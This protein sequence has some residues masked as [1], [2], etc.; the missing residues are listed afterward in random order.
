[1]NLLYSFWSKS[2]P[3]KITYIEPLIGTTDPI[4]D[5]SKFVMTWTKNIMMEKTINQRIIY[6]DK[7][8]NPTLEYQQE[9]IILKFYPAAK[10]LFDQNYKSI[11]ERGAWRI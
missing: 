8:R 7:K 11:S 5:L 2:I 9:Q 3:I 6:K 10:D 4:A 1:M